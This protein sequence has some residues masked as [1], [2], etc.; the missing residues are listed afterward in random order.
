[1]NSPSFQVF[2]FLGFFEFL[3][4]FRGFLVFTKPQKLN[5]RNPDAGGVSFFR[6]P[7]W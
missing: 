3:E 5:G 2:G 4:G 1:V 6:H 7:V